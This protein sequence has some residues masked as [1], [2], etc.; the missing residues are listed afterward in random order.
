MDFLFEIE[1]VFEIKGY[2]NIIVPG[3]PYSYPVPIGIGAKIV[4]E[5]PNG[6]LIETTIAGFEMINRGRKMEHAPFSIPKGIEKNQLP[7]GSKV[8][9]VALGTSNV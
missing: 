4:I 2:R 3:I 1:D 6:Q 8:Y 5:T 7:A 9:L